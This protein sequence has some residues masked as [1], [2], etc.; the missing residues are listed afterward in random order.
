MVS[1]S[2]AQTFK[3]TN[4]QK[5]Q[6]G[7]NVFG[8]GTGVTGSYDYGLMDWLSIGGGGDFYWSYDDDKFFVYGRVNFHL[9]DV[10]G[11]PLN[12]DIYPGLNIGARTEGFGM[13]AHLGYRYFFNDRVGAFVEV[14][15]QGAL[16]FSINL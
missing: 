12:M 1:F 15:N 10:I 16:G 8:Y 13:T 7:L 9:G 11:L 5:V 3:G 4:D 6:L 2:N 14:G